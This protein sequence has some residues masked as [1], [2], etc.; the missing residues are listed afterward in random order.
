M[1]KRRREASVPEATVDDIGQPFVGLVEIGIVV[2][3]KGRQCDGPLATK[4]TEALE[5]LEQ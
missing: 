4:L 1:W 5:R 3:D 2:I